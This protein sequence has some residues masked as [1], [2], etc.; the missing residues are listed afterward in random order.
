MDSR[1]P[2]TKPTDAGPARS[3]RRRWLVTMAVVVVLV[4]ATIAVI[5]LWPLFT[6][7]REITP[8]AARLGAFAPEAQRVAGRWVRPDGGY[9][10]EIRSVEA[11]GRVD[12]SYLDPRAI[13][14]A[15]ALASQDGSSVKL[16][17]ELRDADDPGSRYRL[18]YDAGR[19]VLEGTY[20]EARERRMYDVS[21]MRR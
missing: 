18:R 12:A 3:G 13:H 6:T 9:V 4:A 8:A 14:V 7:P 2:P 5:T 11:G 17:I 21:F 15:K 1:L 10:L 19:D 16:V 20:S